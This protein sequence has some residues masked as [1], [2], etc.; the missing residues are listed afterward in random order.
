MNKTVG[1]FLLSMF[2]F[3]LNST[4]QETSKYNHKEAFDP[5]FAYNPGTVYRSGTG[6][7]GPQ[8]WQNSADYVINA[9]LDVDNN[10][11]IA[12][13]NCLLFGFN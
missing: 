10:K 5:L 13:T 11:V 8:Y 1:I 6:A 2:S 9:T 4:A 3:L 7:P 12:Q